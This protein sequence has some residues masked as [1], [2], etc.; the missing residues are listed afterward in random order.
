MAPTGERNFLNSSRELI[1]ISALFL[2]IL[3]TAADDSVL[4]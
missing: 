1:N 4:T 3:N 2:H